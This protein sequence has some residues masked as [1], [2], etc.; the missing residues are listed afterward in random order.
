MSE[1][2]DF[3]EE[4]DDWAIWAAVYKMGRDDAMIALAHERRRA[5]ELL[6][7]LGDIQHLTARFA[8]FATPDSS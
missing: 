1:P 3:R 6:R 4:R 8:A 5:A 2:I 7:L